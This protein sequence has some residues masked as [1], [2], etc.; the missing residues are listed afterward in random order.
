MNWNRREVGVN[1][2]GAVSPFGIG[3]GPLWNGISARQSRI[4]SIED[5]LALHPAIYPTRDAGAVKYSSVDDHLTLTQAIFTRW[6][7]MRVMARHSEP[8]RASR[9][10]D[11]KRNGLV[12][13]E[14]AAM[15]VLESR[16]AVERRAVKMLATA[17][18]YGAS[19]DAHHITTAWP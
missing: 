12:L 17:L 18:G 7:N 19:S 2:M 1:G 15:V 9:P 16:A 3:V 6:T 8:Q 11:A 10:F 14:G 5:V 4:D 13:D